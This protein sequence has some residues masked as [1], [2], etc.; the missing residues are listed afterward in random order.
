MIASWLCNWLYRLLFH[1]RHLS[2]K[3]KNKKET[4]ILRLIVLP[5]FT[6]RRQFELAALQQ[7]TRE[8]AAQSRTRPA[9]DSHGAAKEGQRPRRHSAATQPEY[10]AGNSPNITPTSPQYHTG[11]N[12]KLYHRKLPRC[13][14]RALAGTQTKPQN[15]PRRRSHMTLQEFPFRSPRVP[16]LHCNI[17]TH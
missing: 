11:I 8:C 15:L 9:T 3:P 16:V 17:I 4:L 7:Q 5:K 13:S 10:H 2:S 1:C 14:D 12:R 6:L